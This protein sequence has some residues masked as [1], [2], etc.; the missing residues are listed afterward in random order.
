M[1]SKGIGDRSLFDFS[2]LIVWNIVGKRKFL[3]V[4][5]VVN[6]IPRDMFSLCVD[7]DDGICFSFVQQIVHLI[8]HISQSDKIPITD[9]H[10]VNFL[11]APVF[12]GTVGFP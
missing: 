2:G 11:S 5:I 1:V 3:L 4:D 10:H 6:F 12:G 7:L 9:F 8:F